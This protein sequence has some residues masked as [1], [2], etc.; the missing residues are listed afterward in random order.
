VI[1]IFIGFFA[2]GQDTLC[3]PWPPNKAT[4]LDPFAKKDTSK[5]F[6]K[7]YSENAIMFSKRVWSYLDFKEDVNRKTFNNHDQK[8]KIFPLYDVLNLWIMQGKI[9]CFRYSKFGAAKNAPLTSPEFKRLIVK[10]DSI[11]ERVIVNDDSE[12][13]IKV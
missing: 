10:Q 13:I 3:P 6:S 12:K 1:F 5:K 9:S 11:E 4:I 2:H 7:Q 8:L